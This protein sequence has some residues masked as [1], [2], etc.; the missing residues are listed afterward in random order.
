MN[1]DNIPF[2]AII[3]GPTNSVKPRYPVNILS[4][5]FRGKFDFI[6]FLCPTFIHNI[7][8]DLLILTPFQNQIDDW[9]KIISYMYG[10]THTLI[11]LDSTNEL[12]NLAFSARHKGISVW[13]ITQQMTSIAKPFRENTAALVL[14][15]TPSAMK[16]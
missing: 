3:V 2:N 16:T 14:F 13:V 1:P 11:I 6:V 12:V 15:Y 8:K 10:G 9:L 7:N 5:T 4:T